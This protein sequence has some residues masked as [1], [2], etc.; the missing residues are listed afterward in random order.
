[1]VFDGDYFVDISM[2]LVL[3]VIGSLRLNKT[4]TEFVHSTT[5]VSKLTVYHIQDT[6]FVF[7]RKPV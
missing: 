4:Y 3:F 2:A 5:P 1:M 7:Y 6:S